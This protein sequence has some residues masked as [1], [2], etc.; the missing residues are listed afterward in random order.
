M[1]RTTDSL[2]VTSLD[3]RNGLILASLQHRDKF[4][5]VAG[6]VVDRYP[7]RQVMIS[8]DA[9]RTAVAL[10]L[11]FFHSQLIIVYLAAFLLSAF[12]V[13]FNPAAA[14]VLPSLVDED[15]IL[16]ANSALW[17]A[18]VISQIA[19]PPAAGALVAIA[20]PGPAFTMNAA[21][22]AENITYKP[23]LQVTVPDR[24]RGR[25]FAF[26]DVTWQT[27]RLASI[28]IGGI[29]ADHYRIAVVYW[30]G[31]ALL[32]AAGTLGLNANPKIAPLAV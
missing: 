17:S 12:S 18:A 14:T 21:T 15:E 27:A 23:V 19:L 30:I 11:T 16:G 3:I 8:T 28:G 26:Y 7:R 4:G 25:V 6:S 1:T 20:G 29:L 10:L 24:L 22:F 9:A 31:G 13:F 2:T 5:F 32:I